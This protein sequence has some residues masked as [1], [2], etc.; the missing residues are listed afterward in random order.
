MIELKQ[1][2]SQM[3][4][5]DPAVEYVRVS[6]DGQAADDNPRMQREPIV[7]LAKL[8]GNQI[9]KE[10]YDEGMTGASLETRQ[11]YMEMKEW[12]E[13]GWVKIVYAFSASRLCRPEESKV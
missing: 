3:V 12:I 10:F 11:G 2:G 9:L 8:H 4:P 1:I 13:Q 5:V 7:Q 6:T